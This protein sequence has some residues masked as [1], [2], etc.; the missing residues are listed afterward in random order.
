MDISEVLKKYDIGAVEVL[1][2]KKPALPKVTGI[3]F[4]IHGSEVVY[5]GQSV[6]IYSRISQHSKDVL[7]TFDSF[8]I[9]ECPAEHLGILEAHYIFKF[10]PL[11][12]TTFPTNHAYKSFTQLKKL[13]NV[14]A[15]ALKL[16]MKFK[17]IGYR[18]DGY[19][20][21]SD[22]QDFEYFTVWLQKVHPNIHIDRCST[23]YVKEYF[24]KASTVK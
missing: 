24:Q 3:Y 20:L 21:L 7:K 9:L 16:W 14:S 18:Q 13:L 15:P 17:G 10:H 6:D 19:Y 11:L 4:L 1:A 23:S 12:N 2:Q 22:F 5:V 8:S